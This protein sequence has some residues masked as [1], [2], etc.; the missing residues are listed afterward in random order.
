MT[1][2]TDQPPPAPWGRRTV[3]FLAALW[4]RFVAALQGSNTQ[5]VQRLSESWPIAPITVPARGFAFNFRVRGVF[6][7]SGE[8]LSRSALRSLV[9]TFCPYASG[10]L[11]GLAARLA[12]GVE[13]HRG[14]DLEGRLR[15][16]LA[17]T[18]EWTYERHGRRVSCR[19]HV[20]VEPDERLRE[21][22]R[23]YWERLIALDY[24]RDIA[25]RRARHT[26]AVSAQWA[27]IL[28]KLLDGPEA[29]GAATM[30]DEQ[31]A[32]VMRE[33]LAD[34]RSWED[35]MAG[36]GSQ[37]E[38]AREGFFDLLDERNGRRPSA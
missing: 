6:V 25:A 15:Q 31:L 17:E 11:Q 35:A 22:I 29:G 27:A 32:K 16:R 3:T 13:P 30:T 8:G 36:L 26:D 19:I 7:W 10:R 38:Y 12:R 34:R 14:E 5:P 1:D 4:R 33:I 28:K 24:E 9:E 20:R 23:P 37:D 18:G 21:H 2:F